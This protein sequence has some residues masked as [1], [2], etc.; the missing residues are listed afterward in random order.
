MRAYLPSPN[1]LPPFFGHCKLITNCL[2]REVVWRGLAALFAGAFLLPSTGEVRPLASSCIPNEICLSGMAKLNL[3][4]SK[5]RKPTRKWSDFP[6]SWPKLPWEVLKGAFKAHNEGGLPYQV[7][8]VEQPGG[9][10][11]LNNFAVAKCENCSLIS[12]Q[13]P[14]GG[15]AMS[16][17]CRNGCQEG[18]GRGP[19]RSGMVMTVASKLAVLRGGFEHQSRG[20]VLFI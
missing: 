18:I 2:W 12:G 13:Q 5:R 17:K 15:V 16:S 9:K 10:K 3:V 19:W 4:H 8:T 20:K 6:I 11:L 14:R 7:L 1:S